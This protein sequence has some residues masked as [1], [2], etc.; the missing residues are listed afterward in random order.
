MYINIE[1]HEHTYIH[2]CVYMYVCMYL[3]VCICKYV[4]GY[5]YVHIDASNYEYTCTTNMSSTMLYHHANVFYITNG[6][7]ILFQVY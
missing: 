4:G 7:M 3:H 6:H 2:V 5:L 1:I